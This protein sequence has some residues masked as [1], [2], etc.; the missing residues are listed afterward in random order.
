VISSKGGFS[1]HRAFRL[2]RSYTIYVNGPGCK[3]YDSRWVTFSSLL[4]PLNFRLILS[5]LQRSTTSLI[6]QP[7]PVKKRISTA[8][9]QKL[10]CNHSDCPPPSGQEGYRDK[11]ALTRHQKNH[12]PAEHKCPKC[13]KAFT[14]SDVLVRHMASG[15]P[16]LERKSAG[17]SALRWVSVEYITSPPSARNETASATSSTQFPGQEFMTRPS[18]GYSTR[19]TSDAQPPLDS[20]AVEESVALGSYQPNSGRFLVTQPCTATLCC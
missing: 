2:N 5:F 3:R 4:P 10:F 17:E 19:G 16:R 14:R 11:K 9:P 15:C 6:D 13:D 8:P 7:M 12:K 1:L 20:R 18:L